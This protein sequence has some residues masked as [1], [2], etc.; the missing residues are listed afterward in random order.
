[1]MEDVLNPQKEKHLDLIILLSIIFFVDLAMILFATVYVIGFYNNDYSYY[2][3]FI[4]ENVTLLLE[5]ARLF[6][7]YGGFV[8]EIFDLINKD[9]NNNQQKP[10]SFA[11]KLL[12]LIFNTET[13]YVTQFVLEILLLL[14]AIAHYMHV[15]YNNGLQFAVIDVLLFALIN[16][17]FNE[18]RIQAKR[19]LEYKKITLLLKDHFPIPIHEEITHQELCSICHENFSHQE[20]KDCRKLECGHIFHLTCIS[21]W[22]RSGSFTCPFCRRQLLQPIGGDAN[23][24]TEST[25]SSI[26]GGSIHSNTETANQLTDMQQAV[27]NGSGDGHVDN[28]PPPIHTTILSTSGGW[29]PFSLQIQET[30]SDIDTSDD[31][32]GEHDAVNVDQQSDK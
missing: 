22:M 16:N 5:N 10:S 21:Q 8:C 30:T 20:L 12:T 3:L 28:P 14:I 4:Y 19:L 11:K 18:F 29:L 15:W 25:T 2:L 9:S 26:H 17:S 23:S 1:M 31:E 13:I 32:E 6:A 24:D 27:T 7:K